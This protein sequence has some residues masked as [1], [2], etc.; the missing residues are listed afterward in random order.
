M[1]IT[2]AGGVD[3]TAPVAERCPRPCAQRIGSSQD[4]GGMGRHTPG[5]KHLAVQS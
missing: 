1:K 2:R 4:A 5:G 3:A